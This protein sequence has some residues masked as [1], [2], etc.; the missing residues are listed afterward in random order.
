MFLLN[1]VLFNFNS[2]K[3]LFLLQIKQKF[4]FQTNSQLTNKILCN[5]L[6]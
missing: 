4:I 5:F 1:N 6:K 2:E 3:E